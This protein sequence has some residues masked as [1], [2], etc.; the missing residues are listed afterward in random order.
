MTVATLALAL[1]LYGPQGPQSAVGV[2][3]FLG[4]RNIGAVSVSADGRSVA[5]TVAGADLDSDV[6]VSELYLWQTRSG[7][8]PAAPGFTEID[9]PLWS[10]DGERLAFLGGAST[11]GAHRA[12]W[13][14][15]GTGSFTPTQLAIP[16]LEVVSYDWAS[17]TVIYALVRARAAR[18]SEIWRLEV[19]SGTAERIWQTDRFIGDIDVSPDGRVIVYSSSAAPVDADYDLATLDLESLGT[20]RISSRPGAKYSPTWSPDGSLIVF[21]APRDPGVPHSQV[22]LY[23]VPKQGGALVDL[24]DAFDRS[25]VDHHWPAGGYL[26]FSAAVG[27]HTHIFTISGGGAIVPVTSGAQNFGAFGASSSTIYAQRESALEAPELWRIDVSQSER[28]TD[29][30]HRARGW[31]L[32]KQEII[33]WR[34]PDGLNIE[35]LLIYPLDYQQTRRYPLLVNPGG[36]PSNRIRDALS[37]PAG[38]QLFA[39]RGYAV[40]AV[41]PRGSAGYGEDFARASRIDL[42]GGDL[43]DVVAGIDHVIEMGVADPERLAIYGEGYGAHL[44][45]W[46]LTRTRRFKAAVAVYDGAP[47][48]SYP[49]SI[50][51]RS[52]V[53]LDAATWQRLEDERSPA[54]SA[55]EI[56]T[57]LLIFAS[58]SHLN[59]AAA[60]GSELRRALQSE[61]RAIEYVDLTTGADEAR[62]PRQLKDLFFRQLRWF[63]KYLK[64]AGADL[65]DFYLLGE[66]VPGSHGWDLRVQSAQPQAAYSTL[67]PDSGRYLDIVLTFRPSS[68]QR[69]SPTPTALDLDPAASI[70]LIGPG[71][72]T[73]PFAGTVVEFFGRETLVRDSTS[74]LKV[75]APPGGALPAV[76]LRIA[77]EIPDNA[78]E[79]LL[80]AKDFAPVRIWVRRRE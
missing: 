27:M 68:G 45:S 3:E 51:F 5:F 38:H 30:N 22:A 9:A 65:F 57:P 71:D 53:P 52:L 11:D 32:G 73:H 2:E 54:R 31:K 75:A 8:R 4:L 77:Y 21:R 7:A 61:G 42:A 13:V 69:P 18:N 29:I 37:E 39:A 79:Y 12:L 56:S 10:P 46:A 23:Q 41:N 25:V 63:D 50:A 14:M 62:T 24:T 70:A 67:A 35:G 16:Q 36:G 78:A 1:T 60:R 48:G 64:F 33:S 55:A 74:L 80:V 6:F 43:V 15:Q 72:S 28:L 34:A 40:L 76:T 20:Q 49:G 59:P 17:P 58:S 26:L 66:W 47:G 44:T 19:L